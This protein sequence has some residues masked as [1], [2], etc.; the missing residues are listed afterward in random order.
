MEVRR[1]ITGFEQITDHLL[2]GTFAYFG[3]KFTVAYGVVVLRKIA[4]IAWEALVFADVNAAVILL[5][6]SA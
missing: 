6:D 3:G 2:G 4:E 5:H 1:E